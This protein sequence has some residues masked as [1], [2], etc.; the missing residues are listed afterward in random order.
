MPR[1]GPLLR[2][3]VLA[4]LW[5]SNFLL[6][7]VGLR[8]FSPYALTLV[9][10]V[11]GA[12]VLA[13]V[14][15]TR[16]LW[17]PIDR[18]LWLPLG[19]AA[20]LATAVPYTLFGIGEQEVS[21]GLAGS[22]NATT[23]L[24]ALAVGV[25]VGHERSLDPSRLAGLFLGFLGAVLILSPWSDDP[26]S[27]WGAV[28]CLGAAVSYGV[29]YVYIDRNLTGSGLP[30]LLI[31]ACQLFLAALL[32]LVAQ[33]PGSSPVRAP[34]ADALVAAALLGLFGTGAMYVL[35]YRL[36]AELGSTGA[37]SVTYL[38]PVVALGLGVVVLRERVTMLAVV[39]VTLVLAGVV[40]IQR[41]AG[42]RHRAGLPDPRDEATAVE[43]GG[44]GVLG[45]LRPQRPA[46]EHGSPDDRHGPEA[47][48]NQ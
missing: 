9:R 22:L 27:I 39:G 45:Q 43:R 8:G 41:P 36:I 38:L 25:L 31:A 17:R 5:G 13:M 44:V 30:S 6:I 29:S 26:G 3:S 32:L 23:P 18:R 16:R 7:K 21:S 10:L 34:H 20:L 37:S 4:L 11:L 42:L 40:L 19:V 24:W 12:A 33:P 46:L 2:L 35:F 1:G 14:M 15:W 47:P 48:G 28:A